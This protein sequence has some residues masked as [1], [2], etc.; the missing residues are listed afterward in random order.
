MIKIILIINKMNIVDNYRQN[1]HRQAA[2]NDDYVSERYSTLQSQDQDFP[3]PRYEDLMLEDE[4]NVHG[5]PQRGRRYFYFNII[6]FILL[7]TY[8]LIYGN[9]NN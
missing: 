4:V 9:W 8:L 6:M 7:C 1:L 5:E 2:D 3:T